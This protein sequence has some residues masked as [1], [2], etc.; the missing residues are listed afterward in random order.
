[1]HM[2]HM[3]FGAAP[4]LALLKR[5]NEIAFNK[6]LYCYFHMMQRDAMLSFCLAGRIPVASAFE[7]A[8]LAVELGHGA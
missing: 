1:M 8:Q 3:Q 7:F 4:A 2:R 6:S 5:G